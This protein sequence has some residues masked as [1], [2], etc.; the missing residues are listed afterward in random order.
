MADNQQKEIQVVT[1]D[2]SQLNI[3]DVE[4]HLNI[5]KPKQKEKK[6]IVIPSEKKWIIGGNLIKIKLFL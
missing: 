6:E 5:Q 3:S 1:G 2:G 4:K